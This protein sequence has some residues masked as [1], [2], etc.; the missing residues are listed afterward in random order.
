MG[1]GEINAA[2]PEKSLYKCIREEDLSWVVPDCRH[3]QRQQQKQ[4]KAMRTIANEG[5]N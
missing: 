3:N 5:M 1:S 2:E 4:F